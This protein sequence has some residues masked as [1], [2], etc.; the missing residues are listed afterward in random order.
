M[1]LLT[2]SASTFSEWDLGQVSRNF[3]STSNMETTDLKPSE[4]S[5]QAPDA[6]AVFVT[7]S[8]NEWNPATLPLDPQVDRAG[9]YEFIVDGQWSCEPGLDDQAEC[10][11]CCGN[12]HDAKSRHRGLT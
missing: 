10:P 8:F 7:G 5:G 1:S 6:R 2:V 3:K 9:H 12:D 11:G 4:F